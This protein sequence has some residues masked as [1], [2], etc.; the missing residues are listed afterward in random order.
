LILFSRFG[1]IFPFC[2]I[3][4]FGY[5]FPVLVYC[6]NKNLAQTTE[7]DFLQIPPPEKQT[8]GRFHETES[9]RIYKQCFEKWQLQA[10]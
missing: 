8:W 7:P 4:P 2:I 3:F 6:S 10:C 9:A 5:I 1:I